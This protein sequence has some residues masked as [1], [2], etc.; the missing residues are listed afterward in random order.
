M[1]A[2]VFADAPEAGERTPL[3]AVAEER[4]RTILTAAS[5]CIAVHGYD[6]V[7][8]RE[9][10]KRSGVSVGLIQHYFDTRDEL[11]AQAIR[12]LSERLLAEFARHT[13]ED[14]GAWQR[15]EGL[16]DRL[17]SVDDLQGHSFMWIAFGAAVSGHPELRPHL[18]RV[19]RSWEAYV[20]GAIEAGIESGELQPVGEVQDTIAIYLAFFDGYEYDMGTGLVPADADE[21]RNR[22]LLLGRAL[23]RPAA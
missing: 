4:R 15:I 16:V 1:A 10:S 18:E 23:F 13:T 7:R 12:H 14:L 20:R 5:E 19:Y 8:L 6:G 2:T 11:L 22:A 17:C 9:V 21:L 3:D